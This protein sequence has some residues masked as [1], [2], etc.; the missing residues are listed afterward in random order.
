MTIGRLDATLAR[1]KN[2]ALPLLF[3]AVA[4]IDEPIDPVSSG[5]ASA[6]GDSSTGAQAAGAGQPMGGAGGELASGG[7]PTT[8]GMGGEPLSGG[9]PTTGGMGGGGGIGGDGGM[10][11]GSGG[12]GGGSGGPLAVGD[13][14]PDFALLDVSTTSP[15]AGQPVSP[16]DYLMRVSGWY[17]GHAT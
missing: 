12:M 10:G 15:T 1:V 8:G 5:G 16:R 4:C 2:L 14:V 13:L 9:A 7:A 3:A 6:G 17:F 11:G